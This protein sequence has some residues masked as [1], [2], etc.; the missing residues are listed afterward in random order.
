M[1]RLFLVFL[2]SLACAIALA[3]PAP[4]DDALEA[5]DKVSIPLH[6]KWCG[7]GHGLSTL[8]RSASCIDKLDCACKQHDICYTE[9]GFG[10]CKCDMDVVNSLK[11][12]WAWKSLIVS[13]YFK[14]SPC[15]GPI[16]LGAQCKMTIIYSNKERF[17]RYTC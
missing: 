5:A 17:N 11:G 13:A 1:A 4:H 16:G 3:M 14:V 9:H 12:S 10:T 2:F 15:R 7:P 6:G 8:P